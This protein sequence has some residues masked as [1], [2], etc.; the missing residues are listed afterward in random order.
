LTACQGS[1]LSSL[2]SVAQDLDTGDVL[3]STST[4]STEDDD[5]AGGP[6][7]RDGDGLSNAEENALG[8]D[9]GNPDTDGDGYQDG[10]EVESYTD[11]TDASD[12]PYQGGW[13]IAACRGDV[14]VSGD[15]PG[16]NTRNFEL[17][18][19]YGD[20][21]RLHDFCDKVVI[22]VGSA[23]WCGP[24]NTDASILGNWY[25]NLADEGLMVITLLGQNMSE[26][27]PSQ[28]DLQAWAS[29]HGLTHPVV[30][31]PGFGTAGRFITGSQIFLPS[32]TLLGPDA[33][34][35]IAD[36]PINPSALQT[37]L[38]SLP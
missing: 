32:T 15:Q 5:E 36:A 18:D 10:E 28:A 37:A 14:A 20:T 17:I 27:T 34:V 7:D 4:S 19:Q 9:P 3:S 21:L 2:S 33:E 35:L 24:C 38:E 1:G 16:Q 22:L 26:G 6:R 31:D 8:S 25:N 11:P 30:A 29:T 13:P 23:T 12:H